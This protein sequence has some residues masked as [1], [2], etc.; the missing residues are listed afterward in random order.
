MTTFCSQFPCLPNWQLVEQWMGQVWH[1]GTPVK[2]SA[3]DVHIAEE[4]AKWAFAL[5]AQ[6]YASAK[7]VAWMYLDEP[8]FDGTQWRENWSVTLDQ[9][10]AEWQTSTPIPLFQL[11]TLPKEK[12]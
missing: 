2:V 11:N 5:A 4:A 8:D 3:T 12:Q 9:R 7:P 6:Y 10:L 1:E